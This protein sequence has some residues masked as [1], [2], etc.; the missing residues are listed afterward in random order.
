[1]LTSLEFLELPEDR[2]ARLELQEG[3]LITAPR[4]PLGHQYAELELALQ[5]RTQL[6][7]DLI[8]LTELDVDLE[9]GEPPTIRVPDV[10]VVPRTAA[11]D[12]GLLRAA[13]VLLAV[14]IMSPGSRRT[15]RVTKPSEYADAQIPNY[16]LV[17]LD[18]RPSLTAFHLAEPFGYQESPSATGRYTTTEPAELTV[19]LDAL[20]LD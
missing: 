18:D 15:D 8:A 20:L 19:D 11:R 3:V 16:W 12:G 9:L 4:P 17:D 2:S 6:P 7:R 14:E 10:L 13:S 5:L 1:M